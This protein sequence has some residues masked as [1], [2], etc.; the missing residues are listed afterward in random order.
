[1]M[2]DSDSELVIVASKE[3]LTP[4]EIEAESLQ[5]KENPEVVHRRAVS[6]RL[7]RHEKILADLSEIDDEPD[8]VLPSEP[9]DEESA[10]WI[11][12][13]RNGLIGR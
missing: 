4:Q 5:V 10:T 8:S 11:S 1:M 13:I 12:K 6:E 9:D 7:D 3:T 2:P